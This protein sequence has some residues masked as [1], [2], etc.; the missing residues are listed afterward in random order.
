MEGPTPSSAIFY[1][2]LSIHMG[3]FILLRTRPMWQLSPYVPVLMFVG[4]IITALICNGTARVQSAIKS[5]I[6]Y[7]SLTQIGLMFVELSL[8]LDFIALLHFAGNA[9]LRTYQLLVSPSIVSYL[10][11][12]QA[13]STFERNNFLERWFPRPLAKGLYV[14]CI[15]EWN[16]DYLLESLLWRPLKKAGNFL[17][18][19]LTPFGITTLLLVSAGLFTYMNMVKDSVDNV[20]HI[21][22]L[23]LAFF[24]LL[25]VLLSFSERTHARTAWTLIFANHVWIT[26]AVS[27]SDK[28]SWTEIMVYLSGATISWGAGTLLLMY[29]KT[30]EKALSLKAFQGH[31]YEHPKVAFWFL[32]CSLGLSGFPITPTFIGEDVIFHHIHE[33]QFGVALCAALS[34]IIDGLSIIRI[35]SR[36]F[37]GPHIK[38]THEVSNRSA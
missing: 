7:S 13:Y 38:I 35:Y 24:G 12:E 8:G 17:H 26:A 14:L 2:S 28:L 32:I 33:N 37:M 30:K 20:P 23:L 16:G 1:G 15:K 4:G 18:I 19:M 10:M 31:V 5:Q 36:V 22:S 21:L 11:R 29:L 27:I 9:F 3:V 25:M 6:A 34:Y